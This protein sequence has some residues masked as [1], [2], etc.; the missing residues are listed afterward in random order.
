[1]AYLKIPTR[2]DLPAYEFSLQLEGVTYFFSFEWNERGQYWSMDI[3]DQDQNHLVAGVRMSV[4]INLL[5]RFKDTR[6]PAGIFILLDSSGKNLDPAVDNF[7]T[8][9]ELFY[10]ESTTVD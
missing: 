5:G 8:V 4:N 3:L 9:V 1:M 7:G 6:L 10:R 2:S